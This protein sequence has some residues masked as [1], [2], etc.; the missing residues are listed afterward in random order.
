LADLAL[1]TG[2]RFRT[3]VPLRTTADTAG[4][5][6]RATAV[7]ATDLDQRIN[8]LDGDPLV[9]LAEL[10]NVSIAARMEQPR[11][12]ETKNFTLATR[13]EVTS[14]LAD[15]EIDLNDVT[16]S[17]VPT[18]EVDPA[19]GQ[20]RRRTVRLTEIADF[21]RTLTDP[22]PDAARADEA[23]YFFGGIDVADFTIGLLRNFEGVVARYRR[24]L[25]RC[26]AAVARIIGDQAGLSRRLTVVDRELTEARQDVATARALLAE[27]VER[28]R[29]INDRRD[30]VIDGHVPF[31][32]FAR[33]RLGK[34]LQ[35]VPVRE[36]DN[37]FEPDA[38]PACFERHDDPPAELAAMLALVR[39][40]PVAWFP[41]ARGLLDLI[42]RVLPIDRLVSVAQLAQVDA[43]R[44]VSAASPLIAASVQAVH[45]QAGVLAQ[46]RAESLP[47]LSAITPSL[48]SRRLQVAQVASLADLATI[49]D[50]PFVSRGAAQEYE[51]IATIAGCLHARLC[52]VRP[53]LRLFWA[54]RFSQFDAAPDL[55][56]FSLL[57]RIGEES[58]ALREDIVELASWLR[59]RAARDVP[60]AQA[61]IDDLLRV[62]LL[63]ASHSPVNEIVTGRVLRPL[64][65][66]PGTLIPIKPFLLDKVRLGMH[67]QFFDADRV[68][69]TAVVDDLHDD[70][71]TVRVLTAA[72]AGVQA[73]EATAVHFVTMTL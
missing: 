26:E 14:R 53:A 37:G 72:V 57:P 11:A 19:T 20:P 10:R 62:C 32:A 3:E 68:A 40:A 50:N 31:L 29:V 38:V 27:E 70:T 7:L 24:A 69:A 66:L 73:T 67:V 25:E 43:V 5:A 65:L 18:G 34:R 42:D 22:S 48:A 71:A 41:A 15:A 13:I 39:R 4:L 63:T 56:D 8:I 58:E 52:D 44:S 59:G 64:P 35:S 61:L 30:R 54:E 46:A 23:H 45:A 36:L 28:V 21:A 47:A 2:L 12:V 6:T 60:R 49:V 9:G 1:D 51:R 55:G 17:G 33:P 16:V